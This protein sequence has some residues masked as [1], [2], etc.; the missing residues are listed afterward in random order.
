MDVE[1][2]FREEDDGPVVNKKILE[3]MNCWRTEVHAPEILQYQ[4]S[5]V[6]QLKEKLFIQ[7][8]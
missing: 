4:S 6:D 7:Q 8:V 1:Q 5:L 2:Y 3:L